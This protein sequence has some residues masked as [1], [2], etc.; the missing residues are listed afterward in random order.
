MSTR[1]PARRKDPKTG[2]YYPN[3]VPMSAIRRYARAIAERFHP[4]KIIL[5]G[6]YAYGTPTPDSDVDLLV[7]MRTNNQTEQSVWIDDALEDDGILPGFPMDLLVRTPKTFEQRL[8]WGDWFL[9]EIV[10]RGKVLYEKDDG[11]VAQKGRRRSQHRR[12]STRA[13][14]SS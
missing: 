5:F 11:G 4:E 7:V 2:H 1:R 9:K 8:L 3:T 12:R 10:A 6:S 13:K 14:A